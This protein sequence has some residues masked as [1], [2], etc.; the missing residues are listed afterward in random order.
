MRRVDDAELPVLLKTIVC[1]LFGELSID[2]GLTLDDTAVVDDARKGGAA[3]HPDA[4]GS[5]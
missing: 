2:V 5:L 4:V 1:W 3:P